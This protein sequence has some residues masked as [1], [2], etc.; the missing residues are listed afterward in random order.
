MMKKLDTMFAMQAATAKVTMS[1]NH[2]KT[3]KTTGTED[4]GS[5]SSSPNKGNSVQEIANPS[6]KGMKPPTHNHSGKATS[7]QEFG[8]TKGALPHA[9][10]PG[11]RNLNHDRFQ[12]Q[13][14]SKDEGVRP[15][16]QLN[17]EE[18][19][20][21]MVRKIMNESQKKVDDEKEWGFAPTK[22]PLTERI[23]M[24]PYPNKFKPPVV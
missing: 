21:G 14:S 22:T 17:E 8:S 3:A 2:L 13:T 1:A 7:Q 11:P 20:F 6:H 24:A 10:G 5:S 16:D 23:K 12:R 4:T 18:L 15:V 9:G 19:I